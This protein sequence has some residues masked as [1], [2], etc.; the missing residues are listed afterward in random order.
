MQG[1]IPYNSGLCPLRD[2][3]ELTELW[4]DCDLDCPAGCC[5]KCSEG[6]KG[7]DTSNSGSKKSEIAKISYKQSTGIENQVRLSAQQWIQNIDEAASTHQVE[8]RY[9][10]SVFYYATNIDGQWKNAK[11]WLNPK[12]NHC[13]WYGI[14]CDTKG[15]VM[16]M[17]LTSNNLSGTIPYELGQM[18]NLRQIDL[19]SN[20]LTGTIPQ[21]LGDIDVLNSIV[22][23]S[24]NMVGTL[25]DNSGVCSLRYDAEL[26]E[27]WVD[28]GIQCPESCC[29]KCTETST[30]G[31]HSQDKIRSELIKNR[32]N[33]ISSKVLS[34]DTQSAR[35]DALYWMTNDD[36]TNLDV[37]SDEFR[38]RYIL[39]LFYFYQTSMWTNGEETWTTRNKH[40]CYWYG[41][42]CDANKNVVSVELPSNNL[43]GEIPYEFGQMSHLKKINLSSNN[44]GGTLPTEV[45][46]L[47]SLTSL[48][49]YSNH[50]EG[51]V[52]DSSA[53]CTQS[54]DIWLDCNI[55]CPVDCCSKCGKNGSPVTGGETLPSTTSAK[56]QG[57]ISEISFKSSSGNENT[58]RST[59][60]NWIKQTDSHFFNVE[61]VQFQERYALVVFFYAMGGDNWKNTADKWIDPSAHHCFWYGIVCDSEEN[62]ISLSLSNNNLSGKM[63]YELASI[64]K[65]RQVDLSS[66]NIS[67]KI[68]DELQSLE[69]LSSFIV[70][71]NNLEGPFDSNNSLCRLRGDGTLRLVWPDCSLQC[72]V[73]CCSKCDK[74]PATANNSMSTKS[75]EVV[76][77]IQNISV[78]NPEDSTEQEIRRSALYWILNSDKLEMDISSTQFD[79]RYILS[80]F[81]YSLNGS[82][83][84]VQDST[85]MSS[86][87]QCAWKGITCDTSLNVIAINLPSNNLNGQLPYELGDL[88]S[89]HEIDVH[90]NKISGSIPSE[91]GKIDSLHSLI[92]FENDIQGS[93]DSDS[94]LC[95]Q[96]LRDFWVDCAVQCPAGCC[97]K[98]GLAGVTP[99]SN[100]STSSTQSKK[101][102]MNS[103]SNKISSGGEQEARDLAS[104]W[105]LYADNFYLSPDS[106][107]FLERYILS[108]L[109]FAMDGPEWSNSYASWMESDKHHCEWSGVKCDTDLFVTNINL[110][111]KNLHGT[112]PYELGNLSSLRVMDVHSNQIVGGIPQEMN[113]LNELVSLVIYDNDLQVGLTGQQD[114]CD[115]RYMYELLELWVDCYVTCPSGCCTKCGTNGVP[116][117]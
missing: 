67:G 110:A 96:S 92:L 19:H 4:V 5:T 102:R 107:Q 84:Y 89:L 61:S 25:T 62:V 63:P 98:C 47:N 24:N 60:A 52:L 82:E 14:T 58:V 66:N 83:W 7:S 2:S 6:G 106:T 36:T 99:N 78:K 56:I 53:V 39:V 27:L 71:S 93:I 38:D 41:I 23:Y 75:F 22:I 29:T 49:L 73:S 9:I 44:I 3:Y 79:E 13:S 57:K 43:S 30:S 116:L 16:A 86:S 35:S 69:L 54:A 18:S 85:W 115:L 26:L 32:V 113:K 108:V 8:E 45:L 31:N 77:K 112:L 1:P 11:D 40:H 20:K 91:L 15:N 90:E 97:T 80:V 55:G 34:D 105:M 76:N 10:L 104:S 65:L 64:K 72:P 109:F 81:Y 95:E 17:R 87:H 70:F 88:K 42:V 33:S 68:P 59:A 101:G 48:Q 114:I 117:K 21:E 46:N 100:S 12:L 94:A 103:V 28:C 111:S 74:N 50:I 37:D 51:S